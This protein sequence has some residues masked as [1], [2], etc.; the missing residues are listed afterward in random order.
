MIVAVEST[1]FILKPLINTYTLESASKF[2][3]DYLLW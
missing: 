3:N 2:Q 1:D